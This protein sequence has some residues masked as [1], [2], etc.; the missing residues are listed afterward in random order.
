MRYEPDHKTRTRERI[1]RNAARKLRAELRREGIAREVI[2]RVQRMRK[3]SGLAVSDRITLT[4]G[5]D[6]EVRAVID[7]HGAWISEEVLATELV[8]ASEAVHPGANLQSLELDG[9]T[10]YVAITRNV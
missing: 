3:E 5:G 7:A 8:F 4:V 2:S 6:E 10:A 1:V 9:I